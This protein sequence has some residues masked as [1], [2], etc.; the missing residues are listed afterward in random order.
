MNKKR[1]P[2]LLIL[3]V[4]DQARVTFKS[5][6]CLARRGKLCDASAEGI[7]DVGVIHKRGISQN[8]NFA[9]PEPDG[10]AQLYRLLTGKL[11]DGDPRRKEKRK[12]MSRTRP[13]QGVAATPIMRS[14]TLSWYAAK[15]WIMLLCAEKVGGKV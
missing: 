11:G 8:K 5:Q 7:I 3:A 1:N 13:W 15:P 10:G 14:I 12:V 9:T 2:V 4:F 6:R